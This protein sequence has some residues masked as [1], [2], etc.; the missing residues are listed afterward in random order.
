VSQESIR[1]RLRQAAEQTHETALQRLVSCGSELRNGFTS[2][3]PMVVDALVELGHPEA[4]PAWLDR[5]LPDVLPREAPTAPVPVAG[6]SAALGRPELE[7]AWQARFEAD[8]AKLGW[9]GTLAAWSGRLAPGFAAAAAHG[10]IR[11]AHAARALARRDS[12][13]RQ[14]ELAAGLA[15]W[16]AAWQSLPGD[17]RHGSGALPA[18]AALASIPLVAPE[19]RRNGGAITTALTALAD[20]PEFD[21]ALGALDRQRPL[22]VLALDLATAF[23]DLFLEQVRSP[24]EA[25][26]YTHA[27]TGV[28]AAWRLASWVAEAD[29][30][31]L[32]AHAWQT[33]AALHACYARAAPVDLP[34]P[35]ARLAEVVA[36]AVRHG[37]EHVIKLAEACRA[38]HAASGD[39]RFPAAAARALA[40]IPRAVRND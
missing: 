33:G 35:D 19:R 4:I 18:R 20:E 25:I 11:S 10:V 22:D 28:A 15:L 34:V 31:A 40:V 1:T 3:A 36:A 5:Y 17:P 7:P 9:R 27:I 13:L 16:A 21:S 29:G 26:V 12:P 2:H 30:A 6:W 23:A 8:I 37:D 39:A 38:F 14:Q 24:G 32:L